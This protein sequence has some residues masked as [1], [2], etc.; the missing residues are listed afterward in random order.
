MKLT[1]KGLLSSAGSHKVD[2]NKLGVWGPVTVLEPAV[3]VFHP[4]SRTIV[5]VDYVE[6]DDPL[7]PMVHIVEWNEHR[8]I[9]YF[10]LIEK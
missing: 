4:V 7:S 1:L 2:R 10:D 5:H 6:P 9:E 3:E 8:A